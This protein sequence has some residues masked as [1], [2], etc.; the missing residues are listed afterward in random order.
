[1]DDSRVLLIG[2]DR[3]FGVEVPD[4]DQFVITGGEIGG[5]RG[6]LAVTN[7]VIVLFECVLKSTVNSRPY[8]DKLVI[9]A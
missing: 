8:L 6:E 9:S 7:P 5:S 4:V 1:M 2:L 3:F